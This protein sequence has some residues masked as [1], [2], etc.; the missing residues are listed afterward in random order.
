MSIHIKGITFLASLLLASAAFAA[1]GTS[2]RFQ[3]LD[4]DGDGRI[5]STEASR[6]TQLSAVWDQIE[7]K[8]DGYLDR[9]EFSAFETME[10][11][12]VAE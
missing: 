8:D 11:S 4:L 5:S 12:N 3:K 1:E 9:S 7:K 2:E 10:E 6:D